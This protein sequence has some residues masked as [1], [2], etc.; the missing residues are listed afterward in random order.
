M[1][2]APITGYVAFHAFM[3]LSSALSEVFN[4]GHVLLEPE[5]K[6]EMPHWKILIKGMTKNNNSHTTLGATNHPVEKPPSRE[7]CLVTG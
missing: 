4:P 3:K 1:L 5:M 6:Y 2:K 7:A